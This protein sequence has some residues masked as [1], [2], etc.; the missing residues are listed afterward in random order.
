MA[1]AG[2]RPSDFSFSICTTRTV[3]VN[4]VESY[5]KSMQRGAHRFRHLVKFDKK[6]TEKIVRT[7][8]V[9]TDDGFS[10]VNI[11]STA[12]TASLPFLGNYVTIFTTTL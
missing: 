5:R 10:D 12:L 9:I 8:S 3:L 6:I 11:W 1:A 4:C 2:L 7:F